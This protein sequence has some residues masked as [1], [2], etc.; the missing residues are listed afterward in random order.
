[1][2]PETLETIRALQSRARELH[3]DISLLQSRAVTEHDHKLVEV[4]L[5]PAIHAA[6]C[7]EC[8]AAMLPPVEPVKRDPDSP[9]WEFAKE[10]CH[11]PRL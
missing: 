1:M 3:C 6:E 9:F 11:Q 7:S 5:D 8:L 10:F 2:N 4:L